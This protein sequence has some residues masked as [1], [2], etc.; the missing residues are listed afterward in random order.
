VNKMVTVFGA[1]IEPADQTVIIDY[2]AKNYG[3]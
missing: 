3:E 1:P 2:L